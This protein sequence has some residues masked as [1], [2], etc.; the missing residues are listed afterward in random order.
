GRPHS[1]DGTGSVPERLP[2][3]SASGCP[4]AVR[5]VVRRSGCEALLLLG[6]QP[7]QVCGGGGRGRRAWQRGP[8]VDRPVVRHRASTAAAFAAFGRSAAPAP[9]PAAGR[10]ALAA[11]T[12]TSAAHPGA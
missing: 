3:L 6:A 9:A 2:G 11:A 7:P 4:G 5:R 12:I 1:G 10:G 8:G